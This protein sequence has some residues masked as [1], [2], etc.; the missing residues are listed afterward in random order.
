MTGP[1]QAR[2]YGTGMATLNDVARVACAL[3]EVAEGEDKHGHGHRTWTIG[4][5]AFAWERPFSKADLKRFGDQTPPEGPI[6]AVRTADLPVPD[7]ACQRSGR[8]AHCPRRPPIRPLTDCHVSRTER[9]SELRGTASKTCGTP[10]PWVCDRRLARPAHPT[11]LRRLQR[12]VRTAVE[13]TQTVTA[14]PQRTR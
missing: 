14:R 3:P 4:G 9:P 7:S 2:Q 6:L 13:S 5:K 1:R 12:P 11:A 8:L 10:R